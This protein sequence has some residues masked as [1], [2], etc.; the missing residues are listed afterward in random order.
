MPFG[1]L[2]LATVTL[3]VRHKPSTTAISAASRAWANSLAH[4]V[5]VLLLLFSF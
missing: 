5:S 4:D 3:L 1:I 2:S